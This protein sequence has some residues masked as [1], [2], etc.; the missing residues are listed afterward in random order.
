M[1]YVAPAPLVKTEVDWRDVR[2]IGVDDLAHFVD[3]EPDGRERG[4]SGGGVDA[5][6]AGW[7]RGEPVELIGNPMLALVWWACSWSRGVEKGEVDARRESSGWGA[8]AETLTSR[9]RR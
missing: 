4:I 5:E 9:W 3:R 2:R 7:S 6:K 1:L 8:G